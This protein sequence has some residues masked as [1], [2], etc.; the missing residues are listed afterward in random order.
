[1]STP[2]DPDYAAIATRL[3]DI[4]DEI[5]D[6]GTMTVISSKPYDSEKSTRVLA[7]THHVRR[8]GEAALDLIN[9]HG[10]LVAAPTIRAGFESA[11]TALWIAQSS[12]AVQA[13]I[14]QDAATRRAIQKSLREAD[15]PQ[16]RQIADKVVGT[17]P[18]GIESTSDTQAD[19][20]FEMLNDLKGGKDLYTIYRLL[21]GFTHATPKLTDYYLKLDTSAGSNGYELDLTQDEPDRPMQI[22]LVASSMLWALSAVR[23]VHKDRKALR[24]PLRAAARELGVPS[25]YQ[26]TAQALARQDGRT[27]GSKEKPTPKALRIAAKAKGL[28]YATSPGTGSAVPSHYIWSV[29]T[30]PSVA[31]VFPTVDE[32]AAHI[33]SL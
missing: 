11:L 19:K 21:C 3:F 33:Q 16:L 2:E 1:M 23:F 4:W 30:G 9:T 27:W 28:E 25:E 15:S 18:L 20:V 10:T 12:D 32:V 17:I 7:L 22:H 26:L 14:A 6:A 24:S 29:G 31:E 13:W 8:L 5:L